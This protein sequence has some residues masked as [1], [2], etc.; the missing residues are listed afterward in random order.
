MKKKTVMVLSALLILFIIGSMAAEPGTE[1][2][3]LVTKDYIE[4]TVYPAVR[5]KLVTVPAGKS[6]V[7]ASSSEI[8]L[9]MGKCTVIGTEKGGVSDVT[10]GYDLPS[11]TSVQGNHLLIVPTDDG[12]GVKTDTEC[13]LMI[14]GSYTIN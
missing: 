4:S 8:V 9:R 12:R 3:P 10:M 2:N 5:F 6:V 1:G 13:I 14:K 11:G 7:C